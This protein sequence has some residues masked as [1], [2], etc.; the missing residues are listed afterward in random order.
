MKRTASQ[1]WA[2]VAVV[3]GF[4]APF[5]T[6]LAKSAGYLPS[7]EGLMA[8]MIGLGVVCILGGVIAYR[9]AMAQHRK[10]Q[11]GEYDTDG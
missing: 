7:R 11:R 4:G 8:G 9:M 2:I 1:R 5:A 6:G 10:Y 3:F